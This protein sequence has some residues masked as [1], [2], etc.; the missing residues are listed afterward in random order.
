MESGD[1][2][3]IK[4]ILF[5]G[6][7]ILVDI[8]PDFFVFRPVPDDVVVERPLKNAASGYSVQGVDFFGGLIFEPCHN[9]ADCRGRVSR[10][11]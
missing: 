6:K 4:T 10:P 2:I 7:G 3:G 11:A 1:F 8:Q 5:P 9:G